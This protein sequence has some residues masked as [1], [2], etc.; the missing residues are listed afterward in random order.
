M[1]FPLV[2]KIVGRVLLLEAAVLLI[3]TAVA[4]AYGEELYPFLLT[5]L[6]MAAL[7]G[8]LSLLPAR[9]RFFT[10]EGF[11]TVGLIWVI[12]GVMGGLP[13]YFSGYFA[14]FMDCV[15]ECSS[16]FTTTGATILPVIETLPKGIL[17]WRAFTH[18]L[19]GMGVL[20][21]ATALFPSLGTS[22]RFLTQA[23]S[24]GPTVSQLTPRQSKSSK[25]LYGIY[26][27]LT[28]AE[29]ACLKLAGMPLYDCFIHAFSSA[30]TGGFSNRNLNVGAYGSPLIEMI[31]AVFLVLFSI[32]FTFYFLLLSRRF[33]SMLSWEEPG[34]FLLI[35]GVSTAV[36]TAD[37]LPY[38]GSVAESF[39]YAF[40][41]VASIISTTGFSTT[42][43]VL[44]PAFSQI[45]LILLMFCGACAGST[46]GGIKCSRILILGRC[47]RRELHRIVHP[48]SVEVVRLD[49]KVLD[50]GT[51]NSVLVF[52][53]CY[54]L[55]ILSATALVSL[56]DDT[57]FAVS[58]S[59]ALTC[60]SNVGPG[61]A[62]I[63]PTGSFA[64]FSGFSK[65]VLSFLMILGRLEI[66]PLLV[67]FI[68]SAW[69][70]D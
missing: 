45:V 11:F 10:R 65:G 34:F 70:R 69:R 2:F 66:F 58:F 62:E 23:E 32:N 4:L 43:Y 1:N 56:A 48:R 64:A 35:V 7:G 31:I 49:G 55:A 3:P 18:W 38:Y 30:G 63:G 67:L 21:L 8:G 15:F 16:G 20:V 9:R 50:E 27:F 6:L 39:R 26:C 41:Q 33:R 24:P 14:T 36:V 53:S 59:A 28:L 52:I 37:L 40:F 25:I 42:D 13:F 61:L 29:V 12:T 60:I 17:F 51:V 44:W 19:G 47:L 68:P 54:I 22:S 5:I 46:G 57:S